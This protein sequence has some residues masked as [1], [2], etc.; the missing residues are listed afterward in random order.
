MLVRLLNIL[1]ILLLGGLLLVLLPLLLVL[2]L[3]FGDKSEISKD[4]VLAYLRRM[5]SGVV[6]LDWWDDFFSVPIKNPELDSIRERCEEIWQPDSGYMLQNRSGGYE[7]NQA[8]FAE[9]ANLIKKC[10]S[11]SYHKIIRVK[12]KFRFRKLK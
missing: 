11:I 4:E 6:D 5:E 9:I 7:L 10:E 3:I 2:R 12:S 8:G 1:K